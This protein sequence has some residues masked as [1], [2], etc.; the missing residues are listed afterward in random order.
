M[1]PTVEQMKQMDEE[2]A[3][4]TEL[5]RLKEKLN[6][7]RDFAPIA[8]LADRIKLW[9][10]YSALKK[11]SN[12]RHKFEKDFLKLNGWSLLYDPNERITGPMLRAELKGLSDLEV[13]KFLRGCNSGNSIDGD[14]LYS[15]TGWEAD[16]QSI[17]EEMYEAWMDE[18]MTQSENAI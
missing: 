6:I 4:N 10:D 12:A 7:P 1:L 2:N 18:E 11:G 15:L 5:W 16:Q 3:Q 8:D 13:Y 17:L 14:F 9:Q